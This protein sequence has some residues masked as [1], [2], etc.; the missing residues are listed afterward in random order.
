M[1][2]PTLTTGDLHDRLRDLTR[3]SKR[4]Q[5]LAADLATQAHTPPPRTP[6]ADRLDLIDEM[7]HRLAEA[8]AALL[9]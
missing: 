6:L 8:E 1:P 9:G 2:T 5:K 7:L 4:L 3:R